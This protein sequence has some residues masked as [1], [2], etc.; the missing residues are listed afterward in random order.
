M[1]VFFLNPLLLRYFFPIVFGDFIRKGY[2]TPKSYEPPN[3]A[4]F[5]DQ[6]SFRQDIIRFGQFIVFFSERVSIE[7][8]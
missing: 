5:I 4:Q 7:L 6:N 8:K 2:K 3:V 1:R